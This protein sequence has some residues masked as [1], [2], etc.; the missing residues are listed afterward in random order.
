VSFNAVSASALLACLLTTACAFI[1]AARGKAHRST[2]AFV[3][4][5]FVIA[6][7]NLY[8]FVTNI[9][10]CNEATFA[11]TRLL[12]SLAALVPTAVL[13]L[14]TASG[15]RSI[16][17]WIIT[18]LSAALSA[19]IVI[20]NQLDLVVSG[21]HMSAWGCFSVAGPLYPLY[22]AN[23]LVAF[24]VTAVLCIRDARHCTD[25]AQLTAVRYWL[26][27]A[28]AGLPLGLTNLLPAYGVPIYPMGNLGTVVWSAIVL[29]GMIRH[30]LLDVEIVS[31]GL[32]SWFLLGITCFLPTYVAL[33]W[34]QFERLGILDPALASATLAAVTLLPA[35]VVRVKRRLEAEF[36]KRAFPYK[37]E[38]RTSLEMVSRAVFREKNRE[39]LL[40]V[41]AGGL[42]A[43]FRPPNLAIFLRVPEAAELRL[44][45]HLGE[46]PPDRAFP[47]TSALVAEIEDASLSLLQSEL[48]ESKKPRAR[49]VGELLARNRWTVC[50]PMKTQSRVVGFLALG[51]KE[52]RD[53]YM[54]T[55]LE[56]LERLGDELALALENIYLHEQAALAQ[57]ALER[58]ERLSAVGTMV[59]GIV[60]E[61]RNPLS[62]FSTFM[63]VAKERKGDP[64]LIETSLPVIKGEI[65]RVQRLLEQLLRATRSK[66]PEFAAVDLV[67][68]ASEVVNLLK[69]QAKHARVELKVEPLAQ[70]LLAF[71]DPD[72]VRQV[73]FNLTLNAIE[74]SGKGEEVTIQVARAEKNGRS[75][76]EVRVR[77]QGPGVPPEVREK[78]FQPFFTTKKDGTGLGLALC[79]QIAEEHQGYIEIR[80]PD[81]PGTIFAAGFPEYV[82][83]VHAALLAR[84]KQEDLQLTP[85]EEQQIRS[86]VGNI[87]LP[88]EI[89]RLARQ[90][91]PKR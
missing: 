86:L 70:G 18:M 8:F 10:P 54:L 31:T 29:H 11:S 21:L 6:A 58:V 68:A 26:V 37:I 91:R 89:L 55:E 34:I 28:V 64:D 9:M 82:A 78:I 67:A 81:G 20:A 47:L 22:A 87:K 73:L 43:V 52:G 39:R 5:C 77:D 27:G 72:R 16:R 80:S 56:A 13:Y 63:Q 76:A 7:W 53:W 71:A 40:E 90:V 4:A 74:A 38:Q 35:I 32:G 44:V 24:S 88:P 59:A 48:L 62:A 12:R 66:T 36:A 85:E 49:E 69:P 3:V 30:R 75:Y 65:D 25:P 83:E 61:V 51:L 23:V 79:L 46:P 45:H 15:T 84:P 57:Q 14:A 17:A 60:H 19:I 41:I 33:L 1:A 2:R 50:V 42:A